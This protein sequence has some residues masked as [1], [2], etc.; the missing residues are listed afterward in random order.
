MVYQVR[1]QQ[2]LDKKV[3]KLRKMEKR[4]Q[5]N[6][7]NLNERGKNQLTLVALIAAKK[8]ACGNQSHGL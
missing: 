1:F 8:E 6:L 5:G 3:E 4:T 7:E 2:K